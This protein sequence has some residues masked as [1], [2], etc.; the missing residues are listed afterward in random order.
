M[1]WT[2]PQRLCSNR[3]SE[4]RRGLSLLLEESAWKNGVRGEGSCVRGPLGSQLA[5]RWG[6]GEGQSSPKHRQSCQVK[7]HSQL[8]SVSHQG[9]EAD[10]PPPAVSVSEGTISVI[11]KAHGTSVSP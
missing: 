7:S 1:G 9:H 10:V 2:P 4:R 3:G 5:R 6:V 11:F 8:P